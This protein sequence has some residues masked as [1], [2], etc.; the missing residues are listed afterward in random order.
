MIIVNIQEN[1]VELKCISN[2]NLKPFEYVNISNLIKLSND[3]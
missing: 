1:N 3:L 2:E